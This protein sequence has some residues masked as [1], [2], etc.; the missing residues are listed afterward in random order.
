MYKSAMHFLTD[1]SS[2]NNHVSQQNSHKSYFIDTQRLAVTDAC[3]I[4]T[5][6]DQQSYHSS[7]I[8]LHKL[9]SL[10]VDIYFWL[11]FQHVYKAFVDLRATF[12]TRVEATSQLNGPSSYCRLTYS[13]RL[14]D[15]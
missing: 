4:M 13:V 14:T 10:G 15:L 1:N 2:H 7:C 3:T 12:S 9:V 5:H 6:Q 8:S 11:E